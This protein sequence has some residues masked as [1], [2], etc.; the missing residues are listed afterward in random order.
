MREK[1][2]ILIIIFL[3]KYNLYKIYNIKY[4]IY[5]ILTYNKY[6]IVYWIS[7]EIFQHGELKVFASLIQVFSFYTCNFWCM[8]YIYLLIKY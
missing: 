4:I 1:Q 2:C 5:N 8:D 3:C 6:D 7:K